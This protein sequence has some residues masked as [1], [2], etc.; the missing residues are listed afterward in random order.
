MSCLFRCFDCCNCCNTTKIAPMVYVSH[1]QLT[2]LAAVTIQGTPNSSPAVTMAAALRQDGPVPNV[3]KIEGIPT[4]EG[5]IFRFL[6]Q[7][8][9]NQSSQKQAAALAAMMDCSSDPTK[10]SVASAI[11]AM[12]REA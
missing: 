3:Q 1:H 6:I 12:S 2:N 9:E 4:S 10:L 7:Q 5:T 8:R 11:G